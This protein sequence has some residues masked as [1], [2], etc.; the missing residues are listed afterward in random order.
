MNR[1]TAKA[2]IETLVTAGRMAFTEHAKARDPSRGK[3][4][5]TRE[6]IRNCLLNGSIT[7]GPFPDIKVTDGWK[8]TVT[9]F[10]ADE[11]H[12]VAAVLIVEKN[13]LVITGY[14][15]DKKVSRVRPRRAE[16]IEND[17]SE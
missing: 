12:E 17:E 6:Q 13:V 4:P 7:E 8:V 11:K 3:Y 5:L 2:A 15:W 16:H 1:H 9:R 14:G 10:K